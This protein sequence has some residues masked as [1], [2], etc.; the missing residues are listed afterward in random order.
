MTDKIVSYDTTL[1]V[2]DPILGLK[3]FILKKGE[4][5]QVGEP[6]KYLQIPC[7]IQNVYIKV[8][9]SIINRIC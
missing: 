2:D 3:I 8:Y 4:V 5:I 1:G 9:S 7:V 6:D